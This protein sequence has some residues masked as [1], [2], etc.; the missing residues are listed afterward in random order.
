MDCPTSACRR[1]AL[2]SFLIEGRTVVRVAAVGTGEGHIKWP[3]AGVRGAEL[4]AIIAVGGPAWI[5]APIRDE[6]L[7]VGGKRQPLGRAHV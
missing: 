7:S 4:R 6:R 5:P 3:V 2:A 1:S